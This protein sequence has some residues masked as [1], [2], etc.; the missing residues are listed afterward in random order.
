MPCHRNVF[1]V[2]VHSWRL[3]NEGVVD[4]GTLGFVN[5]R[6]VAIFDIL[7]LI[8]V[9]RQRLVPSI[10][11]H[12]YG[13]GRNLDHFALHT[14]AHAEPSVILGQKN[15]VTGGES[16]FAVDGSHDFLVEQL[17]RRFS[18]MADGEIYRMHIR[19]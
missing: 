7:I 12:G 2:V 17:T 13:I 10:D 11:L 5:G 8:C 6:R 18:G 14:V 3:Q 15:T 16:A 1:Q 9:Y 19:A 4:G